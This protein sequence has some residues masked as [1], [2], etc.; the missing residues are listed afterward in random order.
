MGLKDIEL[1]VVLD[2]VN[3]LMDFSANVLYRNKVTAIVEEV[4]GV[5]RLTAVR[6]RKIGGGVW[7][8]LDICVNPGQSIREANQIELKVKNALFKRVADLEN[9]TI[10][11]TEGGLEL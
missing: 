9:V 10:N 11:C 1:R 8:D 7:F 3:T 4:E 2:S 6:T 5:E